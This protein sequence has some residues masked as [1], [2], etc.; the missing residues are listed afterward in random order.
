MMN[1]R[2]YSLM[3]FGGVGRKYDG[4]GNTENGAVAKLV[5]LV[6]QQLFF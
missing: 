5:N 4:N 1:L 3:L 6:E 2:S